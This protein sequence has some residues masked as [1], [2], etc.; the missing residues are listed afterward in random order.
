MLPPR[1]HPGGWGGGWEG[2]THWSAQRQHVCCCMAAA[3][4]RR[5]LRY[6]GTG[7]AANGR[8]SRSAPW[9]GPSG[10]RRTHHCVH[11]V[12]RSFIWLGGMGHDRSRPPPGAAGGGPRSAC[13]GGPCLGRIR[14]SSPPAQAHGRVRQMGHVAAHVREAG[15]AL[16]VRRS[17][18][19]PW[20]RPLTAGA[21]GAGR[22]GSRHVEWLLPLLL[23][24]QGQAAV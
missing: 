22:E 11:P 15:R 13:V 7:H 4:A 12:L 23:L 18:S 3:A 19:Q 6:G 21:G 2:V 5:R 10:R 9:P 8:P 16:C 1:R 20:Q 24:S 14:G 17:S